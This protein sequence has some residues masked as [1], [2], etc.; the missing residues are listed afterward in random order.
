KPALGQPSVVEYGDEMENWLSVE[1]Q[2]DAIVAACQAEIDEPYAVYTVAGFDLQTRRAAAEYV[3]QI[4]PA[5]EIEVRPG[6]IGR[7]A[8]F[9]TSA[10][11]RATGWRA[12][13]GM[14]DTLLGMIN[15]VRTLHGLPAVG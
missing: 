13:Y 14:K 9:D 15:R 6:R 11:E 8:R 1:D 3:K 2:A 7:P 5:A 10:M 12:K 4:L